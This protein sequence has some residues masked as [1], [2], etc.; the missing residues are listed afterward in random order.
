MTRKAFTLSKCFSRSAR[1]TRK[2][3]VND[4][5]IFI[6]FREFICSLSIT[7]RG[8]F[9]EKLRWAFDVYDID[10]NGVIS[11]NEVLS[12]VKSINKMM[13]YINDKNASTERIHD[14]FRNFDKNHDQM[15]SLDE[16]I[17]G[18]KQDQTFVLMLQC[19]E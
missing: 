19:T 11:L 6:D 17:E 12:I 7:T 9:E 15:L 8:S 5:F 2:L 18:A 10:G 14:I 1:R 13:G 4:Y 3:Y 16:F